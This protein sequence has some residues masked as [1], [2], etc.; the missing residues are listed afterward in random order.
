[1]HQA[2]KAA[3]HTAPSDTEH[4]AGARVLTHTRAHTQH[5]LSLSLRLTHSLTHSPLPTNKRQ[6][7]N[8][9]TMNVPA[10]KQLP[11]RPAANKKSQ[12]TPDRQ[13][14]SK[15]HTDSMHPATKAA[16]HTAT[17]DTESN[18]QEQKRYPQTQTHAHETR[19]HRHVYAHG[20]ARTHPRMPAR[21][22][23]RTRSL[24]HTNTQRSKHANMHDA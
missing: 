19:T 9:A 20:H 12:P 1:M 3:S 22:R 5:T 2:T 14:L 4:K 11:T 6:P 15:C 23:T 8:Q 21:S 24:T 18:P 16:S 10:T 17:C 7:I 13:M